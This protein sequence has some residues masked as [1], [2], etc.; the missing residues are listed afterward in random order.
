MRGG[1]GP[2]IVSARTIPSRL[3]AAL[4]AF[5]ADEWLELVVAPE[6]FR[7]ALLPGSYL[8]DV[9]RAVREAM[10]HTASASVFHTSTPLT[11]VASKPAYQARM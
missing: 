8:R 2:P 6:F 5:S 4:G 1:S 11:A 9:N 3:A 7:L 10:A